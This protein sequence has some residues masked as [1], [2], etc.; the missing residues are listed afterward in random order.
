MGYPNFNIS[1]FKYFNDNKSISLYKLKR[2]NSYEIKWLVFFRGYYNEEILKELVINKIKTPVVYAICDGITHGMGGCYEKSVP[3]I[4]YPLLAPALGIKFIITE[5]GWD[6]V[7]SRLQDVRF[8]G[9]EDEVRLWLKNI[10]LITKNPFIESL[11]SLSDEGLRKSLRQ[12]LGA[13]YEQMLNEEGNL[14]CYDQRFTEQMKLK[15]INLEL[16]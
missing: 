4:L 9:A 1:K 13:I 16:H 12:K 2:P 14:K 15:K 3:T 11:L 8:A 10:L 5:Q 6:S 7:R